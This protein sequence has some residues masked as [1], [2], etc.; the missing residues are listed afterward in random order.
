MI[1]VKEILIDEFMN[2]IYDKY[3]TLFPKEEQRDWREK[4]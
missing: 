4:S 1:D 3:I 2:D